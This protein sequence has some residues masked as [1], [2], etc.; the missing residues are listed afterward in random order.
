[1]K[2]LNALLLAC[3]LLSA[4]GCSSPA[5]EA[6]A[7]KVPSTP[8]LVDSLRREASATLQVQADQLIFDVHVFAARGIAGLL[9]VTN[10]GSIVNSTAQVTRASTVGGAG[11]F[12]WVVAGTNHTGYPKVVLTGAATKWWIGA[13]FKIPTITSPVAASRV[14]V[15]SLT[16]GGPATL[17]GMVGSVSTANFAALGANSGIVLDTAFHDHRMWRVGSAGF[18][19]IDTTTISGVSA[20]G[21][22]SAVGIVNAD[23]TGEV[24]ARDVDV[25]FIAWATVR[26]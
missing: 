11:A 12:A 4:G 5:A 15:G 24:A 13:R 26:P 18:Y 17:M 2:R 1:V 7:Y 20:A 22:D 8:D 9:P 23:L 3:A 19:K 6:A 21:A 10:S 16:T 25:V 14:G